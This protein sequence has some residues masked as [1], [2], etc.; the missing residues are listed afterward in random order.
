MNASK[1]IHFGCWNNLNVKKGKPMGCLQSVS[2]KLHN[3]LRSDNLPDFMVVAGDNYYPMKEKKENEQGEEDKQK[4][5]SVDTMKQGFELLPQN[6]PIIML[7]G[8]HDL[9]TNGKKQ[10]Y[11]TMNDDGQLIS[12][13]D[14]HIIKNEKRIIENMP[15]I[16]YTLFDSRELANG[17]LMLLIDTS[18][19]LDGN[20]H[21]LPCYRHFSERNWA[22]IDE[23]KNA[24]QS[25]IV[26]TIRAYKDNHELKNIILIGHHPISGLKWNDEIK[27]DKQGN[28]KVNKGNYLMTDMI[29]M[30]PML[31]TLYETA[32]ENNVDY[33]YLCAD[34]HMYQHGIINLTLD[35]GENMRIVQHIAGTGG[36]KLDDDLDFSVNVPTDDGNGIVYEY[37]DHKMDCGFVECTIDDNQPIQFIPIMLKSSVGG[38][39]PKAPRPRRGATIR[40]RKNKMT[41]RKRK[42]KMTIIERI[43]KRTNKKR[44]NKRAIR[45]RTNK[46]AKRWRKTTLRN[47]L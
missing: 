13:S 34:L 23:I 18:I 8:N 40:G 9:D 16:S 25:F 41:N 43:D 45:M 37:I 30:H 26:D 46:K 14:C 24:Q 20:A 28:I 1:F 7:L 33:Y 11:F 17:T 35:N 31:N 27:Y 4:L 19:Y 10:S 29:Q 32:G 39:S 38:R 22:D 21:F 6:I 5:I 12:E 15:N 44:N 47:K 2:D 42:N 36:T 3:Y